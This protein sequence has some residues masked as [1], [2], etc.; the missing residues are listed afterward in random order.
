[1]KQRASLLTQVLHQSEQVLRLE[2]VHD[3]ALAV[4]HAIDPA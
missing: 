3:R 4:R 1:M 2:F